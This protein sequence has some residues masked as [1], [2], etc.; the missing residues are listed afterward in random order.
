MKNLRMKMDQTT[1]MEATTKV[2]WAAQDILWC[3][4]QSKEKLEMQSKK[5]DHLVK[6]SKIKK[7]EGTVC[8]H[9]KMTKKLI[10]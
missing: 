6:K 7:R 3:L 1:H 4:T 9:L 8:K 5:W 2:L 10:H